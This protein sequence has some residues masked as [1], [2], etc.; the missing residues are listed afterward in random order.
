MAIYKANC[1]IIKNKINNI[2]SF[3][4]VNKTASVFSGLKV[5]NHC[6]AQFDNSCK[7]W[8]I[9]PDMSGIFAAA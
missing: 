6:I 8:L 3:L 1:N 7:S 5:T 2:S 9:I 4:R